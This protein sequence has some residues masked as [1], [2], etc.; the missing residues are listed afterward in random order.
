[1]KPQYYYHISTALKNKRITLYPQTPWQHR[2]DHEPDIP[3][4][5]V[6]PSIVKCLLAVPY[7]WGEVY[8]VY[9]TKGKVIPSFPV[10]EQVDDCHLTNEGWL[11]KKTTFIKIGQ[12]EIT[13]KFPD[14]ACCKYKPNMMNRL[15]KNVEKKLKK[16]VK[17][18]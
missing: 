7:C 14:P 15:Y 1:M 12:I 13:S 5:C 6:G 3:R 16:L 18:P 17:I 9:R 2:P 4:I 8:N 10:R 11:L